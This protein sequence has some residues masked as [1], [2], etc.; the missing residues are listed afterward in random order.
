[1]KIWALSDPH[2]CFGAPKK[3]MEVFGP[4][5]KNYIDKIYANWLEYIEKEDLVLIPGDISWAMRLKQAL[6][7]L[8]WLDALPGHKIILRG[9][10]D[11]WW[12]SKAKLGQAMPSS[13][14]CIHND[15]ILWQDV[16]IGG[17]R[18]WDTYE[19]QFTNYIEFK[20]NPLQK[21][22]LEESAEKQEA[23]FLRELERLKLSLKQ[24][25]PLARIRIALTHY[26][27][28]GSHLNPS[29]ASEI[30]EQFQIQ[31]CVFG[32]LHNVRRKA[33]PFGIARGVQYI[34]TSCDYLDFKPLRIL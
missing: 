18:L 22:S 19:Y 33:L 20:E 10:H 27:P 14:Q 31:Y 4:A 8:A 7:D 6:V 9:N 32:H 13:I 15:A 30:L 21:K 26:P 11:Y 2:L 17:S 16:A 5:W 34:L 3:S 24:L 12:S 29:R 28:I 23:I 1:M 25:S